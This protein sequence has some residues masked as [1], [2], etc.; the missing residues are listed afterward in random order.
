M[1]GLS[2]VKTK[3]LKGLEKSCDELMFEN[4]RLG[5]ELGKLQDE[6]AAEQVRAYKEKLKLESELLASKKRLDYMYGKLGNVTRQ[7]NKYEKEL[8]ALKKIP[9]IAQRRERLQR[10]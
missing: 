1:F 9:N 3:T 8:K 2:F 7:C 10:A 4:A 5:I 6:S